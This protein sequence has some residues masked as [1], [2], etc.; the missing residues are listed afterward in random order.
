MQS[1]RPWLCELIH[2]QGRFF[3]GVMSALRES[4]HVRCTS[5]YPLRAK[6]G[7]WISNRKA[8]VSLLLGGV[9]EI[10]GMFEYVY[11]DRRRQIAALTLRVDLCDQL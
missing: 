3:F 4:G 11:A 9:R 7:R 6:S 1:L 10:D 8:F 5:P 2:K